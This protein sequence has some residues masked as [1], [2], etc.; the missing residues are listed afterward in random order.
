MRAGKIAVKAVRVGLLGCGTVGGGVVKLLRRN[1]AMLTAKLGARLEIAGV[2][3]RSLKPDPALG[4]TADLITRDAHALVARPDI[5]VVVELFGGYEPAQSLILEALAAGKDVVTANKALLA[6]H[7]ERIFKAAEKHG[8]LVGFEASVGGGVPIIRTLREALAADR[9]RAVYGI[10]NG[11]CNYILTTMA[12]SGA[13]FA[14]VLA[15]AQRSGLAEADPSLDV[16]GHDA[17]HKLCLLVTL[18][19]GVALKPRQVHTEG[20]IRITLADIAY[21]RELGFTVKLLAIAKQED[22]AIE[23]RVHPTMVPSRHLLADVGGAYNAIYIQGEALGSTMYFGLGAGE[24]PTATA[25]LADIL[26]IARMRVGGANS[27]CDHP[28]GYP[29]AK[30]KA[31]KVKPMDRVVCEYY[32]RFMAEDKPGVLGRIASVLGRHKISMASVMQQERAPQVTV[33]VVMRTH[34]CQERDLK[35]A[36]AEIRRRKIVKAEPV[37]IRIEE[38]L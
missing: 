15:E 17:A 37:F 25:V 2:A 11:T 3:D 21:A 36:L 5:D 28:L 4:L 7:G 24:M 22:G 26:E 35:L 10:V 13:E 16:G 27:A 1:A 33:P 20:I 29:F 38:R 32:L 18:A 31:A 14:N 9:Q 23:A 8:R 12:E 30:I 34:E 19:F 6:E